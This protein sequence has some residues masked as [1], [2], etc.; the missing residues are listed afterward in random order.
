MFLAEIAKNPERHVSRL[1][2]AN[3]QEELSL[4]EVVFRIGQTESTFNVFSC[5]I[6]GFP[7]T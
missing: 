5:E 6:L 7:A 2:P 1:P 3:F 4:R